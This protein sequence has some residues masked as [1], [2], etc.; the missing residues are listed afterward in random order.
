MF[1]SSEAVAPAELKKRLIELAR[2][3]D[4]KYGYFVESLGGRL[5]PRILRRVWVSDGHEELVR[6]G[7][8]GELDA[9]S[10]RSD[11]L[12]AGNDL[13]VS[14][15][16]TRVEYSLINPSL[17]FD[18]LQVKRVDASKDKLPEYEAPALRTSAR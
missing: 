11:L 14:N 3:H 6:G 8:F 15:R 10:L 17:L 5:S 13:E 2:Q 18:E 16:T 9:R 7:M 1:E 12:A 4:L